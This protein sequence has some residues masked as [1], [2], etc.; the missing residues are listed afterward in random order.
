MKKIELLIF[1][2]LLVGGFITI[3]LPNTKAVAHIIDEDQLLK[4]VS[5]KS[6]YI[7]TDEVAQSI[8]ET[9]PSYL[10]I[11]VRSPEE[12]AK[13]TIDGAINIPADAVMEGDNADYFNQDIYTT[14]LF[15]NGTS[16]ADQTWMRLRSYDYIGNKV[17]KGGLNKWYTTILN[18]QKPKDME[19]SADEQDLYLFRKGASLYFTGA[20]VVGSAPKKSKSKAGKKPIVKRKKKAVSGG[21]G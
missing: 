16:L 18:P 9:D 12:F 2:V 21:C 11:D 17:L 13:Y 1:A 4:E 10:Y 15:S 14:V 3:F 8:I 19:L 7:S 6:R 5:L 20:Q